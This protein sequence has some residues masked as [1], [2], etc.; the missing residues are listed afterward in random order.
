[1]LLNMSVASH[2]PLFESATRPLAKKLEE[3]ISDKF[4]VP[5]I[6]NVTAQKYNTKREA[7]ELLPKQLVSPVKYK[8][9]IINI[10]NEVDCYIEF[11]HGNVLKGLN[12][13]ISKKP[14][15]NVSDMA[16]FQIT[17]KAIEEL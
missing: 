5:I 13:K 12:R 2:C 8:H 14:H 17:I 1:M 3:M 10:D 4:I 9:S 6:S 16:S 15:F 11:G 7:L